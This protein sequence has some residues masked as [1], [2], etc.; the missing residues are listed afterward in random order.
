MFFAQRRDD[1][2][3]FRRLPGVRVDGIRCHQLAGAVNHR[4][5]HAGTQTWVEAHGRAQA[6]RRSHQ[7]IVEVTGEDVNGFIFRAFAHGAHQLGFEVHQHLD[8]PGPAHHAFAPAIRRGA[9]QAQAEVVDNNLFA[10]ALFRRFVELWI[11]VER[12]LQNT[13][14]AP[15]EHRQ[16]AVGRGGGNRFVMV[17]VVAEFRAFLFLTADHFGHQMGVL[18][19]VVTYFR[20]QACVFGEAFHQD[21]A[22]AVEGGFGVRHALIG[23]DKFRRLGFRV[24]RR[25]APQ[26]IGQRLKTRFNGNLPAGTALLF[27]R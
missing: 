2:R 1:N 11:G 5:L 12:E 6:S 22:R 23:I 21:I 18:P 20:Q 7:Q 19:Q 25:F 9:V 3:G 27:V 15:A 26:Q 14:I 10:V 4:H 8:A 24:V 16:R 17:E 13:F